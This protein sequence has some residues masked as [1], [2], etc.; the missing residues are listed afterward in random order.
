MSEDEL[1]ESV[2][3]L[4]V[5]SGKKLTKRELKKLAKRAE[6]DKQI[7][8]MGGTVDGYSEENGD[9]RGNLLYLILF[10]Y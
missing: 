9:K 7:L 4:E 5:S 10:Q 8:A 2:A 6:Y 3:S 1:S